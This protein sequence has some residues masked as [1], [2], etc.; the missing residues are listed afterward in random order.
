MNNDYLIH[1][2]ILGQKWGVRRYQNY[3]GSLKVQGK[4]Q[5][6]KNLKDRVKV[7]NATAKGLDAEKDA[8]KIEKI[9]SKAERL[10]NRS[11]RLEDQYKKKYAQAYIKDLNI[12]KNAY[13]KAFS[14][15]SD[16]IISNLTNEKLG[17]LG[18]I[19][20]IETAGN[21]IAARINYDNL[22][23]KAM[24][25]LPKY[26]DYNVQMNSK[27]YSL[28]N[29][30]EA[31]YMDPKGAIKNIAKAEFDFQTS[32]GKASIGSI[33][34]KS[35][36]D[37]IDMAVTNKNYVKPTKT[38]S[39]INNSNN[40]QKQGNTPSST[41]QKIGNIVKKAST[42]VL[43][44]STV[45]KGVNKLAD[46]AKT[47]KEIR[48]KNSAKNN[49]GKGLPSGYSDGIA[50]ST[51]KNNSS[52]KTSSIDNVSVEKGKT[53]FDK[54]MGTAGGVL[55]VAVPVV[56]IASTIIKTRQEMMR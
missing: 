10:S 6:A 37:L 3:D 49:S 32:K 48:Q 25:D 11:Q 50:K 22:R 13:D 52:K 17:F 20:S 54:V 27:K 39:S 47:N 15:A 45:Y 38:K 44:A 36:L 24:S 43:G 46:I 16:T 28:R 33:A 26:T 34:G 56:N 14:Q 19:G 53:T 8:A 9:E 35:T 55:A 51:V 21:A 41:E 1:H 2:G 29:K 42:A 40:S 4:L 23:R 31:A 5:R 30:G 12:A 18:K 7:L